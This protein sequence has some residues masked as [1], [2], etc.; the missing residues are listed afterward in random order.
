MIGQKNVTHMVI[1]KD[2]ALLSSGTPASLATGQVGVFKNGGTVTTS[3]LSAGDIFRVAFKDAGGQI[4]FTPFIEYSNIVRKSSTAY[5][6]PTQKKVFVGYNG[7]TG[8][9][10]VE[11]S[12][13]YIMNVIL[14]DNT[15]AM[16][17]HPP[18]EKS[19]YTSDA[20]ATEKEIA[21]GIL[22][23]ALK[24]MTAVV[25]TNKKVM[26]QPGLICSGTGTDTSGGA[27]TVVNGSAVVTTVESAG[28]AADA[29]KYNSDAASIAVGDYIRFSAATEALT[30]E[31]YKVAAISGIGTAAATITLDRPFL[32]TS[33]SKAANTV[34]VVP[35]ATAA[36]VATHWGISLT[37]VAQEFKA[38]ILK[39]Q[40][41]DF[42]VTLNEAFSGTIQTVNTTPSKGMGSYEEIAEI[43]SFL[44]YNRGEVYRV[45]DYP[46]ERALNATSGKTYDV[47]TFD[48][49]DESVTGL[50]GAVTAY[51]SVMIATEDES[52]AT[53]NT[54]LKTVLGIS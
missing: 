6:A 51:G 13:V 1:G 36:N 20:D 23:N 30:D 11:N 37:G 46:V 3:A 44:K 34:S 45:A 14:R 38:G 24:N 43:E 7:T 41:I 39:Y 17:E 54:S 15:S 31:V 40:V 29:G 28:S 33:G 49:V 2:L 8:S 32:G 21:E 53:L 27:F 5:S 9:I 25:K 12:D 16:A 26:V 42:N 50:T 10:N 47:I 52:S 18:Y 4:I 19:E 35:A 22:A 48:Y